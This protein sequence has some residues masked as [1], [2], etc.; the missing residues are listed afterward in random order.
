MSSR[1]PLTLFFLGMLQVSFAQKELLVLEQWKYDKQRAGSLNS[2]MTQLAFRQLDQRRQKISQLKTAADWKKRQEEVKKIL[3]ESIGG[4]PERTPLNPVVTGVAERDGVKVEKLYYESL[5]G[6]YVTAALFT[7]VSYSGKLPAIVYC[8]GHSTNGFRSDTYQ[9]AILNYVKKGFAVLAFDPVGQGERVQYLTPDGSSRM[10]PTHE[11]SY[12]GSQVFMTGVSPARYFI[13]DGIRAIDYLQTRPEIDGGRIGITGRSGGGTQSAY[14]AALDD[15]VLAAAPECYTTT[16]EML[17]RSIGPQDAEQN[18]LYSIE[19]G[20]DIPDL[21]E[22][23]APKPTLL[24]TTYNDFFSIQGARDVYQEARQAFKALGREEHLAMAEDE[25]GHASTLRNREAA[26]A[27]FRKYLSNPGSS[28][29][30]DVSIFRED[31]LYVTPTGKVYESL[32]GKDLREVHLAGMPPASRQSAP[33]PEELRK[34]VHAKVG[35]LTGPKSGRSLYSGRIT[36][37]GYSIEKYLVAGPGDVFLPVLYFKPVSGTKPAI[38]LANDGGKQEAAQKGRLADRLAREG[39]PVILPDLSGFGELKDTELPGGDARIEEVSLNLWYLGLLTNRTLI[40]YRISE[41]QSV[42]GFAKDILP[43]GT[44]ISLIGAGT[45]SAEVLHLAVLSPGLFQ[46]IALIGPLTSYESVIK[47][48]DFRTRFVP[49]SIA[50]AWPEYDLPDLVSALPEGKILVTDARDGSGKVLL[51]P[52]RAAYQKLTGKAAVWWD[53][54]E[55]EIV[56]W[57]K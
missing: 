53:A 49:S 5:P 33:G 26:Y 56:R 20:F 18:F 17:L 11:H 32:G 43:E 30:T 15:R 52:E 8:S 40:G 24:I 3:L 38:V 28:A 39:H 47:S 31:E 12:P 44:G 21:T 46:K 55:E 25:A 45:L 54:G 7:P 4:F 48:R 13:W 22:L 57:L 1:F 14:I 51:G 16:F 37:E 50:G 19:K 27:F 6:Y 9:R 36:R 10:G 34:L 23:R 35:E 2:R 29:E 42:L 41:L